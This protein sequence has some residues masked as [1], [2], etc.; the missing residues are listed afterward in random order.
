MADFHQGGAITTLHRL[1][2]ARPTRLEREL[3][4]L[5]PGPADRA[6]A[7]RA[8]TPS[9]TARGSRGSSTTLR[10]VPTCARSSS[11]SRAPTRSA[12]STRTCAQLFEG[13]AH[14][15]ARPPILSG[16]S[17]PRVQALYQRLEADGLDAGSNGKGRATWLAFGYVLATER[18]RA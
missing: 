4:S 2:R 7:A 11:A 16:T 17:G 18:R 13:V 1:G 14:S 3:L 8:W 9:S 15:T 12:P 6:R 10:G 5:Q